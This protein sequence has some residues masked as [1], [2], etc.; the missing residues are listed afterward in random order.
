MDVEKEKEPAT[1]RTEGRRGNGGRV[2][3]AETMG[4]QCGATD[5]RGNTA[6]VVPCSICLQCC[7]RL[8]HSPTP[9][10]A[11]GSGAVVAFSALSSAYLPHADT[12]GRSG[13]QHASG[14]RLPHVNLRQ[15]PSFP[16]SSTSPCSPCGRR[17]RCRS[18]SL[19][20]WAAVVEK[21]EDGDVEAGPT[22]RSIIAGG[23][24]EGKAR[25]DTVH[26]N[27]SKGV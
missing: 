25:G 5:N 22:W 2:P 16:R 17:E 21:E 15:P 10:T 3:Q 20:S 13:R 4:R 6:A 7:S 12:A 18:L 11:T 19:R 14:P 1:V 23:G 24:R 8:G 27:W 9:A 26:T